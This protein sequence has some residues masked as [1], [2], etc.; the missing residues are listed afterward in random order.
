MK[1]KALA[2]AL[3]VAGVAA[4]L[5][6]AGPPP[7]KGKN[8]AGFEGGQMPMKKRMPKVGFRSKMSKDTAE[9]LLY[10]LGLVEGEIIDLAALRAAKLV[11]SSAKY[12][13][14]VKKGGEVEVC[15]TLEGSQADGIV[16]KAMGKGQSAEVIAGIARKD[17]RRQR[18]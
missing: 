16:G 1:I 13:K 3:F 11:P 7:G 5:A 6:L 4:S 9:V 8:K 14:I 18:A 10:K 12:A 2:F 17:C 15:H